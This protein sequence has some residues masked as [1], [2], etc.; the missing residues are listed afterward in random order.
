MQGQ[1]NL[2]A[3]KQFLNL[4]NIVILWLLVL[5]TTFGELSVFAHGGEDHA[6]QQTSTPVAN[7]GEI[8]TKLAKA[9]TAE[10]LI[11]YQTP[12]L[13]EQTVIRI[14]LTD[15]IT[16]TP[17]DK[18]KVTLKFQYLASNKKD[19]LSFIP[20]LIPIVQADSSEIVLNANETNT[21]GM[22]E[23]KVTFPS[24]GQYTMLASFNSS[25]LDAQAFI[26][27]I[28]VPETTNLNSISNISNY[29]VTIIVII[30]LAFIIMLI[31][32]YIFSLAPDRSKQAKVQKDVV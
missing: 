24:A 5:I 9:S 11:K 7:V 28:V 1:N 20:N 26:S 19:T 13:G 6:E 32:L 21:A 30:I 3:K 15:L 23:A 29:T 4:K 2:L 31:F 18:A 12:K 25:T 27:G 8:N 17:I 22:Y 10:A 14:F 16:N